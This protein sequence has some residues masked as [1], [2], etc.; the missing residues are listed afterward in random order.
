[1]AGKYRLELRD[2]ARIT[3]TD[4]H[5]IMERSEFLRGPYERRHVVPALDGLPGHLEPS[6]AGCADDQKAH[7]ELRR[8]PVDRLDAM[9]D[10]RTLLSE[11]KTG[12]VERL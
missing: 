1:V 7:H 10:L 5:A 11:L 6:A 2:A 4:R 12:D 8:S 3:L 9:C